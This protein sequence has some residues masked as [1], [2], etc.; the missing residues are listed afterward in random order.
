M[1]YQGST[2][3]TYHTFVFIDVN[4]TASLYGI[5]PFGILG[6]FR[7]KWTEPARG[8]LCIALSQ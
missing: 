7:A 4:V 5:R 8:R 2:A 6:D 3:Y 1:T